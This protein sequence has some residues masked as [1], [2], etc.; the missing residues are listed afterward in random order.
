MDDQAKKLIA[1]HLGYLLTPFESESV[2]IDPYIKSRLDNL[3]EGEQIRIVG[4]LNNATS[5]DAISTEQVISYSEPVATRN[6]LLG[7]CIEVYNK[8]VERSN[9]Q[10]E[11]TNIRRKIIQRCRTNNTRQLERQYLISLELLSSSIGMM[12]SYQI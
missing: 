5:T 9:L 4:D 2:K 6:S 8:L 11:A 1:F 7:R 3:S 12:G 10:G